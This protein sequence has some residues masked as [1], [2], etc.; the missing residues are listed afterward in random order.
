MDR[1][2]Q[3]ISRVRINGPVITVS[4]T[5]IRYHN[6][7]IKTIWL[8]SNI[9]ATFWTVNIWSPAVTLVVIC[10]I[11]T[12][13]ALETTRMRRSCEE[14]TI[15]HPQHPDMRSL[16]LRNLSRRS[17]GGFFAVLII[18]NCN[19]GSLS[20]LVN[21]KRSQALIRFF[22]RPEVKWRLTP[23]MYRWVLLYRTLMQHL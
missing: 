17:C 15:L 19:C 12:R 23:Q 10:S 4:R 16:N 7:E 2:C 5:G 8:I 9:S 14:H 13:E 20:G 11:F 22:S 3:C 1:Y 21:L 18:N 6:S